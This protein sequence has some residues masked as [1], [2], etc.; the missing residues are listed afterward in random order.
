MLCNAEVLYG[1]TQ[2]H[3]D[4][5]EQAD[6]IFFRRLFEVPNCTAIEAFHLET[7]TIPVR[8]L[9]IKKRLQCYWNILQREENELVKKV[10][11][12]Q[13][14]FSVK[15]DWFLQI[16]SYLN[17]CEI[18]LSESEISKMRKYSFNKLVNEKINLISAQYLIALKER[19]SKSL[20]LKYSTEM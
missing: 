9:L 12:S 17:E 3:I 14:S 16:K 6:I 7:S 8:F 2:A 18:N 5:L 19:H 1:I 10:Y 4:K 13:K 20:N 11:N 15:N